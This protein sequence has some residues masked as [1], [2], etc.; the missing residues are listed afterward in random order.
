MQ[1]VLDVCFWKTF[2]VVPI[3]I[4]FFQGYYDK[5]EGLNEYERDILFGNLPQIVNVC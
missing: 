4:C 3:A 1:S 5:I 2:H